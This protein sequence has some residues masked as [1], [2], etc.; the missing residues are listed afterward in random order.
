MPR[1]WEELMWNEIKFHLSPFQNDGRLS[2][3]CEVVCVCIVRTPWSTICNLQNVET[4]T[5]LLVFS[6][7]RS[8]KPDQSCIRVARCHLNLVQ[9]PISIDLQ[10]SHSFNLLIIGLEEKR[11]PCKSSFCLTDALW[12][13]PKRHLCELR[14]AIPFI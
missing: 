12:R 10:E 8:S 5:T 1:L 3:Y 11:S 2:F 9:C 7:K 4:I 6:F 14:L 13:W